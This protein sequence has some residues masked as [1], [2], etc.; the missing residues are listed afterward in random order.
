MFRY[1]VI[2]G[3][4]EELK[5]EPACLN[6]LL[7]QGLAGS[8]GMLSA[9][10]IVPD[11]EIPKQPVV[12]TLDKSALRRILDN[13]LS[14]AAKYSDGDLTV[15][16]SPDGVVRFENH[17]RDLDA[18][19]TA[20]LFDCFFTVNTARGGTGL[21]VSIAKLLT[22]KMGGSITAEYQKGKLSISFLFR[23]Y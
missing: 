14:N 16:L 21:G 3:A 20:C 12:R 23:D 6:D 10:G 17:A 11:I 5:C 7:E 18:V 8:Y 9:H 22:E 19:Q 13:I 4:A 15:R 2:V 1:S